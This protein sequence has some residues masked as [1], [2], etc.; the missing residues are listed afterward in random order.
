MTLSRLPLT[1]P[2]LTLSL[3]LAA[4]P[5]TLLAGTCVALTS[6]GP[7][8][9]QFVP[10]QPV[11]IEVVNLTYIPIFIQQV[12]KTN[13][14]SIASRQSLY[15]LRGSTLSPNFS[16]IFW[17]GEGGTLQASVSQPAA[18]VLRIEIRASRARGNNAVYLRDDGQVEV[19]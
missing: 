16:L 6:C 18:Q 19:F 12:G 11:S 8:P 4:P 2:L 7:A 17:T 13:F 10:G 3:L 15:V 14:L 5:P 9:M 1:T